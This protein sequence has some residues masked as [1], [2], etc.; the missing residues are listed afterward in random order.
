MLIAAIGIAI[1]ASVGFWVAGGVLLRTAGL[2]VAGLAALDLATVG[3]PAAIFL[4]VVGL[5]L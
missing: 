5:A 1:I 3:N 4:F 2:V